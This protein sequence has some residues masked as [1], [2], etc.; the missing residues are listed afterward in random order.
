MKNKQ[1]VHSVNKAM[2]KEGQQPG[3]ARIGSGNSVLEFVWAQ[4]NTW[5]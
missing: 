3:S 4:F 5:A 2:E 1:S